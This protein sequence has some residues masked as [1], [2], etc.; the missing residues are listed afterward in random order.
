MNWR[1]IVLDGVKAVAP[2]LV[3]FIPGVG[4]VASTGLK[5]ILDGVKKDETETEDQ[6]FER[7]AQDPKLL[8]DVKIHAMNMEIE[9]EREETKRMAEET[10]RLQ[11][12]NE[13][14]RVETTSGKGLQSWWRPFNGFAFGVTLFCDYILWPAVLSIIVLSKEKLPSGIA[15]TPDHA[16]MGIYMLW[17]TLLGATAI[18]RSVEKVK[19]TK[20]QN[21]EGASLLEFVKTMARGAIGK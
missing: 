6:V 12:L 13:T 7:I 16:P 14:M 5:A 1:E 20:Q 3:S 10:K 8:A 11:S 18:G 2:S 9:A 15:V 4:A 21:G 19:Q 17:T